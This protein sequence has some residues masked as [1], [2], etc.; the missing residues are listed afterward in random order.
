MTIAN[1]MPNR[2][3]LSFQPRSPHPGFHSIALRLRDYPEVRITA[4]KSYWAD[5]AQ[6]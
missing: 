1:H 5:E 6:P 2:Y 4:R 3:M